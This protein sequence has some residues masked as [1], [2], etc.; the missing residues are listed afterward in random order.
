[1]PAFEQI[2]DCDPAVALTVPEGATGA[3]ISADTATVRYRADGTAP[4]A[5]IGALLVHAQSAVHFEGPDLLKNLQF[6][7]GT[8]ILNVQYLYS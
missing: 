4:T 8:G 3:L 7:S 2:T 1:M 5:A 6:F